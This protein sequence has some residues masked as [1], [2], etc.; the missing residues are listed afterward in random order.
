MAPLRS[1]Y[2]RFLAAPLLGLALLLA[3]C[4]GPP[5]GFG[6]AVEGCPVTDAIIREAARGIDCPVTLVVFFLQWSTDEADPF[7]AGSV[8]AIQAAGAIP[9]TTWE[10]MVLEGTNERV[11]N[12]E[13][14]LSGKWDEYIDAFAREAQRNN[15]RLILRFAHEMNLVRYHWGG[16]ETDFGPDS[17]ERYKAMFRYVH[18]RFRLAGAD[19][20]L[21]AFCPNA[22]SL[23]HPV[24]DEATWN[25]AKSY[26]PGDDVVDVLGMDGYNWGTTYTQ[27]KDGW[28]SRFTPFAAIFEPLRKELRALAPDKPLVVFETASVSQGG[29]KT[30]WIKD[31]AETARRWGL[32]GLCWFQANKERDWRLT[33]DVE[34]S[35]LALQ[36]RFAAGRHDLALPLRAGGT[37]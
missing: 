23:P 6:L 2:Y 18:S 8:E 5:P 11:V 22:E 33:S 13:E 4:E 12:A 16:I 9:V 37:R 26:Y 14:I 35:R 29:D 7:P 10:P 28:D 25:T 34:V 30:A 31:A 36:G 1:R 17:P 32:A 27:A 19:N 3:A 24:R 21:F 15:G 20:V